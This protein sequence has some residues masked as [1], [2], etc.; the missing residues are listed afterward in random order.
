M[1]L[2]IFASFPP[3][4][5]AEARS[6]VQ[7]VLFIYFRLCWVF[8]AAHRL[9]LIVASGGYSLVVSMWVS[10]CGG[11]SCCGAWALGTQASV[12][13]TDELSSPA[14]CEIFQ[15]QGWSPCPLHWQMAS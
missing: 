8:V 7:M 12:V 6:Q 14:V 13:V 10:H 9:S 4:A 15:D 3:T 2:R 5:D 1:S 11:F